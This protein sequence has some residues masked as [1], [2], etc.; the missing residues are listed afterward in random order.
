MSIP[1]FLLRRLYVKGSLTNVEEGFQFILTNPL[2]NATLVKPLTLTIDDQPVDPARIKLLSEGKSLSNS[3]ISES[4]PVDFRVNSSVTVVV[5]GVKLTP[6]EHRI[7]ISSS[8][9]GYGDIKFEIK[10]IVK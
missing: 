10:D 3:E 6:G 1:S 9:K 2:A 8:V 7:S 4:S 5:E